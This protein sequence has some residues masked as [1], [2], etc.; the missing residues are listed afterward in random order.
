MTIFV[1][2]YALLRLETRLHRNTDAGLR[3]A[4]LVPMTLWASSLL[5]PING[6]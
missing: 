4:V 1:R 5:C 2:T 3:L 6:D